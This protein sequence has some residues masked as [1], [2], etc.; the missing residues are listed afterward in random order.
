LLGK[1]EQSIFE[2]RKTMGISLLG[3]L[4]AKLGMDVVGSILDK[5]LPKVMD[6]MT[7]GLKSPLDV[8]DSIVGSFGGK[9]SKT[10]PAKQFSLALPDRIKSQFSG[11]MTAN[12]KSLSEKLGKLTS[13]FGFASKIADLLSSF[14]SQTLQKAPSTGQPSGASGFGSGL[15]V[16]TQAMAQSTG[17]GD[18][19]SSATGGMGP[20]DMFQK[21]QEAQQAAQMFELAVKI[22]DIQHQAAMSAIRGIK[23]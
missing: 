3:S 23:Y 1:Q 9:A 5:T 12:L 17:Y 2:R 8:F 7:S 10:S 13:A 6:H 14:Q 4:G 22:S 20:M 15:N 21:M 11:S 16:D 19:G 18:Q